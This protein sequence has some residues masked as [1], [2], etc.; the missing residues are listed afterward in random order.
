MYITLATCELDCILS[1]D[2]TRPVNI[3]LMLF[4]QR[5]KKKVLKQAPEKHVFFANSQLSIP[6]R[7]GRRTL[8]T[9]R[10]TFLPACPV[11]L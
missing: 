8:I 7:S 3:Q 10:Q 4:V 11:E 9:Q 1:D 5:K 2:F 6:A